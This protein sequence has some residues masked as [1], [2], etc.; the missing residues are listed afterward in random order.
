MLILMM[1]LLL[2]NGSRFV[3]CQSPFMM[4]VDGSTAGSGGARGA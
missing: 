1:L 4:Q 3:G 2:Y